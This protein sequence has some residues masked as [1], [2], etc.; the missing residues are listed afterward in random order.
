LIIKACPENDFKTHTNEAYP[1]INL[2]KTQK[3]MPIDV[4]AYPENEWISLTIEAYPENDKFQQI[5][6]IIVKPILNGFYK[7]V[8]T[9]LKYLGRKT[10]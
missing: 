10:I 9:F 2:E 3:R 8:V 6:P 5:S 4:E 7:F 1:K